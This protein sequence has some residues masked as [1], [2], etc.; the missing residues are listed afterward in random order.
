MSDQNNVQDSMHYKDC[1]SGMLTNGIERAAHR[2]LLYSTGLEERDLRKPLIAI[3]NSFT[4]MVPGHFHLRELAQCVAQGVWEAGGV[5]REFSTI[6]ICDG[7]CQ[8]H[9]G[10]SY[11]LPSR[12]LIADSVEYMI[13]AHRFDAMV[14]LPGCDKIVPGMLM[15]A[16]RCNI[17]AIVVPGGPMLPG[18]CKDHPVMT[19][20][21]MRELIGQTQT[22][23]MTVE[24]LMAAEQTALPGVGTCSMLGTANTM[25]CLAEVL[26]M[27]LPGCGLAHAVSAK[28]RRIAKQ[29]GYRVVEMLK[30][31]LTPRKIMTRD[32]LRNA[33]Q[34]Y[35]KLNVKAF[36]KIKPGGI[37]FTFSCSQ[38]VSK[39]NFRTA[40][41][42]AAAMSGRSVRILH[43]LTQ[44]ADHP[45][46]IYH[47][48][49]E[50]LKGL[51]LYVE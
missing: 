36:E 22:G 5:P 43:Q 49:G 29:S 9:K 33:L 30:E 51:V 24:E 3:V 13:E 7:I 26:G 27:S 38:A 34:G 1:R 42:T 46:S 39:E 17:P 18:S 48:E 15:G 32:A 23:K 31:G 4:E 19:L 35:R 12:E 44:P 47:P 45:V 20:T 28:K 16:M 50:Y 2:A 8:G 25:S 37:L 6:A 10:M 40:V 11:P 41:F 21:D 14:M